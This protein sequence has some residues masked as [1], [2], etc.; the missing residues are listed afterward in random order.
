M[1][2]TGKT[3]IGQNIVCHLRGTDGIHEH[4]GRLTGVHQIRIKQSKYIFREPSYLCICVD[5]AVK[6]S[7]GIRRTRSHE[8]FDPG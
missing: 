6:H 1:S 4:S 3:D 7:A 8:T 2:E 5:V